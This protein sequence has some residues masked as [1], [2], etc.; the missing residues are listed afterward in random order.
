LFPL[1]SLEL[2]KEN[3][4]RYEFA[5]KFTHGRVYDYSPGE[6]M[7]YFGAKILLENEITKE[8]INF[9]AFEKNSKLTKRIRLKDGTINFSILDDNLT[10]NLLFDTAISFDTIQFESDY[11]KF[12]KNFSNLLKKD[13][14]LILSIPNSKVNPTVK[15][16][17]TEKLIK[18]LFSK[19]F[20]NIEIYY[21]KSFL[22]S[23][24]SLPNFYLQ[25][26]EQKISIRKIIRRLYSLV[27]KDFNYFE[28]YFKFIYLKLFP[29]KISKKQDFVPISDPNKNDYMFFI[30]VCKK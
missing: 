17:F 8:V 22:P 25:K 21:Q 20:K 24:L 4:T 10:Q 18:E 30:V 15:N 2:F 19:Y 7:S 6:F 12:L 29:S 16:K 13:G 23:D 3:S 28:L 5:A 11:D 14:T 26:N 27:D 9:N 1:K